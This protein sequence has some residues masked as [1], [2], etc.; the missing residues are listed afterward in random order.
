MHIMKCQRC[1]IRQEVQYRQAG[2]ALNHVRYVAYEACEN[3]TAW[4]KVGNVAGIVHRIN[5]HRIGMGIEQEGTENT[6]STYVRGGR[7][8]QTRNR[9]KPPHRGTEE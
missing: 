9:T 5:V 4:Q 8:I 3:Q 2:K 6:R 1:I 7:R